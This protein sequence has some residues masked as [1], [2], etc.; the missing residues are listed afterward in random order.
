M[1]HYLHVKNLALIEEAEV[2]FTDGLNI[3]TGETGAGKSIIIG[4]INLALGEKVPK[5]ML[6]DNDDTAFVEL[7]FGVDDPDAQEALRALDI[8]AEDGTVILNR[9]I[10]AG[11][12]VA[13]INGE[14]VPASMLKSAAAL[15]IDIHGQ[16][17]HQSLLH[18][19]KH[20]QILDAY[21]KERLGGLPKRL[22]A[23]CQ[24]YRRLTE[25]WE[26]ANTDSGTRER[27]LSL[28]EYEVRE[29]ETAALRP[30]EDE[31]L[32]QSFRRFSNGRRIMDAV[33]LA[34]AATGG[35]GQ[36]ASELI[37]RAVRELSAV[38]A[39]DPKLADLERQLAEIDGLLSDFNREAAAYLS[40]EE[41]DEE[42][43][44]ETEKRLDLINH[45][46]TKYSPSIEGI[47]AL[48]RKKQERIAVLNDYDAYL[49][50][51]EQ[52]A[53]AKRDELDALCGEVSQI[54]KEESV[55]LC[56]AIRE[57]LADLN[58]L[59]VRFEMEFAET[60][61]YTASGRDEVQFL[62]STNPGEPIKPLASV[63][64]GGELS[65]VMLAVKTV[66][67]R[68]DTETLIFDEI[69]S[70]IS[71]RTAQMVAEKLKLL[72][73]NHQII[74]ITHLPQLAAMADTHF[75]IEKSVEHDSTT[76]NIRRLDEARSVEE[77]ARMLGGVTITETV[78]KNAREMRELAHMKK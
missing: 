77:L 62:I 76:S 41:F 42:V 24:E 3:L 61:D 33:N 57:A 71:G 48:C 70:G 69:D 56:A 65:R 30:G 25:E 16:N 14:A 58:F 21:A 37:G 26:Q 60:D 50:R 4:S 49:K 54:R 9:R 6:R 22:A 34:H 68:D 10:T 35:D 36:S 40:G 53:A 38:S 47:L 66:M 52:S 74:C 13:K 63:A 11:R 2:E 15:L 19:R 39:C 1:L 43:C 46:K 5:G 7:M 59:D 17:E 32:E 67:A 29:I 51:L 12:S 27:E 44:Y 20:L 72:A 64:S 28:L 75:L 55:R 18:R 73:K 23:C 31:E 8:D 45:L 78:L